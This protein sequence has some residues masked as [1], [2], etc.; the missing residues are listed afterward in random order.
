MTG[1]RT[2]ARDLDLLV[3]GEVNPDV[4]VV[5]ADPRPVF[6]QAERVVR[7][8]QLVPGSSSVI[9][10]LGAA[11]LGLRVAIAGVVGDDAFGRF[12]LDALAE[13][14]IDV[15]PCRVDP[16]RPTGASVILS[17]GRDRAILTATGTIGDLRASDV[18]AGLLARARHLHV[19]SYFLQAAL[20]ADLPGL[21]EAAAAAG[22]STSIDPNWDPSGRWDGGFAQAA[23][24]ADILL[25]NAVEACRLAGTD[26]VEAAARRLAAGG[27]GRPRVVAVKLGAAGALAVGTD[28]AVIRVPALPVAPVDTTRR[29]RL[30]QRR[31]P[32]RVAGRPPLLDCLRVA[33]A[34][35]SLS[36]QAVG[37]TAA[38]PTMDEVE[39]ALA[40]RRRP[41]TPERDGRRRT[42]GP[43]RAYPGIA[44][45]PS[46]RR[47]T[48]PSAPRSANATNTVSSPAIEPTTSGQR[49][50]SRAAASGCAEPGSVRRTSIVP[51]S[52]ISTGM[53]RSSVRIRSSPLVS[54]SRSRW[55][56]RV[57]LGAA[58]AGLGRAQLRD[59]PA[60]RRLGRPEPALPQGRR[61]LL[62][63][64]DGALLHEVPDRPLAELLHDLHRSA[65]PPY[66]EQERRARPPRARSGTSRRR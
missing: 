38:Q 66:R 40:V 6:G 5:D 20:A 65:S 22:S 36:T 17:D 48:R 28:G 1:L 34:C 12:M 33:V 57:G 11:R 18:P 31:V 26:D 2:P 3:A 25:P 37:G 61:Q 4:V 44:A 62:L 30:V 24:W 21:L 59:V 16:R 50:R 29:R 49:A 56:M 10:A 43:R 39:A 15:S 63:G 35:G 23:L 46:R 64:P 27:D 32:G 52:R 45:R 47:R 7:T 8:V 51:A 42:T 53:S 54:A 55:G 58:P 14:G 9:T 13:R 60:D 19:G 41:T